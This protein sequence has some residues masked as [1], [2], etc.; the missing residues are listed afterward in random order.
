MRGTCFTVKLIAF[1]LKRKYCRDIASVEVIHLYLKF[2]YR[3]G[4]TCTLKK[5]LLFTCSSNT[6]WP[7]LVLKLIPIRPGGPVRVPGRLCPALSEEL[8]P[9]PPAFLGG[10]LPTPE[11]LQVP[12]CAPHPVLSAPTCMGRG[13]SEV[14]SRRHCARLPGW[15]QGRKCFREVARQ[16]RRMDGRL[17]SFPPS[18]RC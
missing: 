14:G 16:E 3:M 4:H 1:Y 10:G 2:K 13:S 5:S 17:L 6:A 12:L 15:G 18:G 11:G 9:W 7:I 8:P